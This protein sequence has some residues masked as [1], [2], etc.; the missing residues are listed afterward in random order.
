MLTVDSQRLTVNRS[1]TP[2]AG[3]DTD[4]IRATCEE[5]RLFWLPSPPHPTSAL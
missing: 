1:L 5:I 3:N 2:D 4:I